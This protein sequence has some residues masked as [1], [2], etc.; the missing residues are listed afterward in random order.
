MTIQFFP[1]SD[2]T[3]TEANG[4]TWYLRPNQLDSILDCVDS[5]KFRMPTISNTWHKLNARDKYGKLID[6]DWFDTT[7]SQSLAHE[8]IDVFSH[9]EKY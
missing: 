8:C 7:D 4:I 3:T 5:N 2:S 9:R 6:F 1:A